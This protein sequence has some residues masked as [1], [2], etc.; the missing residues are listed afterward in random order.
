[1]RCEPGWWCAHHPAQVRAS[2]VLAPARTNH[3][4][5]SARRT[6]RRRHHPWLQPIGCATLMTTATMAVGCS[7][8]GPCHLTCA[9]RSRRPLAHCCRA[10]PSLASNARRQRRD[11]AGHEGCAKGRLGRRH[12]WLQPIGGAVP[13]TTTT[14]T[15]EK[16]SPTG[17]CRRDTDG[18][19]HLTCAQRSRRC[20]GAGHDARRA[21]SPARVTDDVGSEGDGLCVRRISGS[22]ATAAHKRSGLN[23]NASPSSTDAVTAGLPDGHDRDIASARSL[24]T[25][26]PQTTTTTATTS[27]GVK[28]TTCLADHT[29]TRPLPSGRGSHRGKTSEAST[30][31]WRRYWSSLRC[32]CAT[33]KSTSTSALSRRGASWGGRAPPGAAKSCWR[34]LSPG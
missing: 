7:R 10:G 18:S 26:P 14:T 11:A 17:P 22:S 21:R 30:T 27:R 8:S 9:R 12:L 23:L 19:H 15:A 13:M 2:L 29:T 34:V 28:R 20:F 32:R 4:P 6:R 3:R 31:A 5:F 1:M 16:T 33:P 25:D 24:Y